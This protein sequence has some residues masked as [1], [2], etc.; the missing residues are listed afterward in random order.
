MKLWPLA[1]LCFAIGVASPT[2]A[3]PAAPV[4]LPTAGQV[5]TGAATITGGT[6]SSMTV[7]QS[8]HTAVINWDKFNIGSSVTTT[9]AQP[10]ASSVVLNRVLGDPTAIQGRLSSNGHVWLVSPAGIK[11]G[12]PTSR[13]NLNTLVAPRQSSPPSAS[14]PAPTATSLPPRAIPAGAGPANPARMVD[15]SVTLR[16]P[17][18]DASPILFR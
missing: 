11:L 5:V 18:V 9:F 13:I 14:N 3:N 7:T 8:S 15:G 10:S 12:P 2:F 6:G 4:V 17:L 1:I 16:T